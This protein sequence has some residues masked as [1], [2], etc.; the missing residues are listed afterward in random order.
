MN[1]LLDKAF[2]DEISK[3]TNAG[4]VAGVKWQQA[5]QKQFDDTVEIVVENVTFNDLDGP[6]FKAQDGYVMPFEDVDED[7]S[8]TLPVNETGADR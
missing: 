4:F 5:Q 8:F 1:E 7:T 3:A 2:A 6:L